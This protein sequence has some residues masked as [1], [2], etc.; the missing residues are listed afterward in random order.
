MRSFSPIGRRLRPIACA[1]VWLACVAC[2]VWLYLGNGGPAEA[3]AIAETRTFRVSAALL[4]RLTALNVVEGQVVSAGQVIARLETQLLEREIAV[5]RAGVRLAASEL[6]AKDATLETDRMQIERNFETE[7]HDAEVALQTAQADQSR[8]SAALA[9][10]RE[11]VDRESALVR[12]GLIRADRLS[13][14]EIQSAA[15]DE[16]VRAAP[17]RIAAVDSRR[18]SASDRLQSWRAAFTEQDRGTRVAQLLPGRD[19]IDRQEQS[20]SLLKVKL[21]ETVLRASTTGYI[22]IIHARP[23]D[24]IRAGDPIVT[25]VETRPRLVIAYVDERRGISLSAG[26][27]VLARRHNAPSVNVEGTVAA[28]GGEVMTMPQRLWTNPSVPAW[29]RAVYIKIPAEST[30]D[31]GEVLEIRPASSAAATTLLSR[32]MNQ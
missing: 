9:K 3:V 22:T 31:P 14:L 2:A 26:A 18:R 19:S 25:L 16:A 17:A 8:D 20:L 1:T 11:E 30:L 24:V 12:R 27:K 7:I 15:L 5:A 32:L 29:G 6:T 23:G 10:V 21:Q 13:Q 4:G 28:V